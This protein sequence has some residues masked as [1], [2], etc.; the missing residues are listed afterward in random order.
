MSRGWDCEN[1]VVR[2]GYQ[3]LPIKDRE[4]PKSKFLSKVPKGKSTMMMMMTTTTTEGDHDD[5]DDDDDDKMI[6]CK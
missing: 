3:Y 6:D 2:K 1:N 5:D 4:V